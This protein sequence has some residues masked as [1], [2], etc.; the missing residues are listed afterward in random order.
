[1]PRTHQPDPKFELLQA[2]DYSQYLLREGREIAFVLRQLAARRSMITA[3]FGEKNEFLL[4]TVIAVTADNKH[5]LL[6]LGRD[7]SLIA[8]A[9]SNGRLLCITQLDKV[10]IQFPIERLERTTH[11]GFPALR[12]PLPGVLLRLQRREYYRL[13]APAADTLNCQIPLQNDRRVT[14]RVIDISGGGIAVIAPPD[15]TMFQ[16]EMS[17]RNCQLVLPEFGTIIAT[18]RVRNLFRITQ[19][20]GQDML[21]AGCQFLDLTTPMANAIQRYIMRA[22]QERVSRGG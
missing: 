4:T 6:D 7:E 8:N 10:K 16:P 1:M 5:L 21:R 13:S 9:L 3:H 15:N 12:A 14:A 18:V 22:E 17:F 19:R 11:E 2:D 20:N